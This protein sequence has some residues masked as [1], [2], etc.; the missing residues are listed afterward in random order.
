MG[1][2]AAL[3]W[4]DKL[5]GVVDCDRFDSDLAGWY[6]FVDVVGKCKE[7]VEVMLSW[8]CCRMGLL[9]ADMVGIVPRGSWT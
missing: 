1:T 4:E 8:C 5:G 3:G 6:V 9:V 7:A 2:W